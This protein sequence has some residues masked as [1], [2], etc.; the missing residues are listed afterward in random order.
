MRLSHFNTRNLPKS[1]FQ[2]GKGKKVGGFLKPLLKLAVDTKGILL[3]KRVI[4]EL[5]VTLGSCHKGFFSLTVRPRIQLNIHCN[6]NNNVGFTRNNFYLEIELNRTQLKPVTGHVREEN[7]RQRTIPLPEGHTTS[8]GASIQWSLRTGLCRTAGLQSGTRSGT[9]GRSGRPGS[10]GGAGRAGSHGRSG[11]PGSHGGEGRPGSHGG[12]GRPG[13]HGGAGRAGSHGS[14]RGHGGA[15]SSRGH[16]GAGR[17]GS[18]GGAGR[19]GSHGGAG[20]PGSHGG[21][22]RPGSHGGAGRPGSHGG[23]GRPGTPPPPL[24]WTWELEP[25]LEWTRV[26]ERSGVVAEQGM[27][28]TIK[29][30]ELLKTH[31]NFLDLFIS[32]T[33]WINKHQP[34]DQ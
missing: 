30:T 8:K 5:A 3:S 27:K 22:G 15:G 23:A 6:N 26:C 4:I 33:I 16:G 19:A 18:H 2:P 29:I 21:A 32:G 25:F 28:H 9:H 17:P 14:S 20:R 7:T 24:G 1:C 13:S 12:E 10:H 11:R 31:P 34:K